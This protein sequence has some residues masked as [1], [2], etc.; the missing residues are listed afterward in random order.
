MFKRVLEAVLLCTCLLLPRQAAAAALCLPCAPGASPA[1]G[2]T[3][4]TPVPPLPA[5]VREFELVLLPESGPAIQ[6]SPELPAGVREVRWRMPR[7]AGRTARLAFRFGEPHREWQSPASEAFTLAPPS[8][9]DLLRLVTGEDARDTWAGDGAPAP[10]WAA[11]G[12]RHVIFDGDA[13]ARFADEPDDACLAVP[14]RECAHELPDDTAGP[15]VCT[16]SAQPRRPRF[17]PLRN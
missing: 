2:S 3:V 9:A 7:I 12:D 10:G 14:A 13:P 4:C 6:L 15:L 11:R 8:A 16:P 1:P 17:T 5:G